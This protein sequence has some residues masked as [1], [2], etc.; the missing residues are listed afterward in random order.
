MIRSRPLVTFMMTLCQ[1]IISGLN[2]LVNSM[3]SIMTQM[4]HMLG[5][6]MGLGRH[7]FIFKNNINVY[8]VILLFIDHGKP[9]DVK[10]TVSKSFVL[11]C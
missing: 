3:L 11:Q 6:G 5:D 8:F 2:L 1:E 9:E 4:F 10:N 7:L